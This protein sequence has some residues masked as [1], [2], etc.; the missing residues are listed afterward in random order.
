[1][2]KSELVRELSKR[3]GFSQKDTEKF[4]DEFQSVVTDEL[5]QGGN[6]RL[7]GFA[8]FETRYREQR[9]GVNPQTKEKMIIEGKNVP[10]VK[11][12]KALKDAVANSSN[13]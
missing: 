3:L 8:S 6:V 4:V 9:E 1:M 7:I 2:N 12:G 13:K 5:C 11:I 10:L